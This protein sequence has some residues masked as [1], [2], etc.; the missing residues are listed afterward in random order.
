MIR[1]GVSGDNYTATKIVGDVGG[2]GAGQ[3]VVSFSVVAS[4]LYVA[5]AGAGDG[6]F[7][8]IYTT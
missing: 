1:C 4:I 5:A 7:G 2:A 6:S 3:D 8:I